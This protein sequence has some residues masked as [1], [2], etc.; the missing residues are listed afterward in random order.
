MGDRCNIMITLRR[1]DLARF[2]PFVEAQ[3][4]DVW[5]D[6]LQ[7]DHPG[8]VTVSLYDVNYAL[9]D[10]RSAATEAGVQFYGNH[11]EGDEYGPG[12]FV[13]WDGKQYEAPLNKDGDLMIAVDEDLEP[14]GDLKHLRD[15]IR[16]LRS[17]RKAFASK[18]NRN[19]KHQKRKERS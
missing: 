16:A 14:F 15:Y 17:I 6:E 12:A 3:P 13:S 8:I 2:A 19:N 4:T 9:C 7:E 5:W 1:E 11:C 18:R 10:A